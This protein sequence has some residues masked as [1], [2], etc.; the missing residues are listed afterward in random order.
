M[1]TNRI[2]ESVAEGIQWL[3]TGGGIYLCSLMTLTACNNLF[4]KKIKSQGELD[5]IVA[6]EAEKL[7]LKNVNAQLYQETIG[8]VNYAKGNFPHKIHL[9]GFYATRSMVRH[10]LYHAFRH[11]DN[12]PSNLYLYIFDYA[13]RREPQAIIYEVFKL[14]F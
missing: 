6:E 12:I 1:D 7:G 4:S 13:F 11:S 2:L 10:E 5:E 9:G 14:K 8:C 3:G